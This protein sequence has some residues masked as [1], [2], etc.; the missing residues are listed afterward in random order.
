MYNPE[1][2]ADAIIDG[3]VR[4]HHEIAER[5][6]KFFEELTDGVIANL[7]AYAIEECEKSLKSDNLSEDKRARLER[8]IKEFQK[9]NNLSNS[10]DSSDK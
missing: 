7:K 4:I 3:F 2:I 8:T 5:N 6:I 10:N 1:K 9:S